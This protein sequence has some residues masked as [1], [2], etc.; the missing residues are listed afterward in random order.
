MNTF[1]HN[2]RIT[3]FGASHEDYIGLTIDGY[4]AGV[5]IDEKLIKEKLRLRQGL[6][7]IASKRHEPDRYRIIGGL[8]NNATT[9][10]PL[11]FIVPNCDVD[12]KPYDDGYGLARP[13]HADYTYY[14]KYRGFADYR[15]GGRASGR[16]TVVLI[17]L[18]AVCEQLFAEH[19][20]IVASRIKVLGAIE[21]DEFEPSPENLIKLRGQAMPVSAERVKNKML[22]RIQKLREIGNSCGGVVSTYVSGLPVGLGNPFFDGMESFLA[23]LIFSV[24]GVKGLEFGTGFKIGSM[25]GSEANDEMSYCDDRLVYHSN[26]AGGLNGGITNG[27]YLTFN[28]VFR[29]TPSVSCEQK[30]V[31]FLNK[32]NEKI[33]IEGRHDTVIAIK[34][35]HVI[36]ALTAYAVTE[37]MLREK[38]LP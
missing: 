4:P 27:N 18:G 34:G 20:I 30:T 17:I 26:H 9:G 15:G 16:L 14:R 1:G 38:L 35:L 23:H 21:D 10:A 13:T 11:V 6:N 2:L 25:L 3:V 7:H 8:F 5:V 24:P 36:N 32:S 12:S 31:N 37:M 33:K 19:G 29:P 22:D 28:T